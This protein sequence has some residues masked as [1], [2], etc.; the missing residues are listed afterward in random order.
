MSRNAI[1]TWMPFFQQWA[2]YC[3][4]PP[5]VTRDGTPLPPLTSNKYL[6]HYNHFNL[7]YEKGFLQGDKIKKSSLFHGLI[8]I[9][10]P[11]KNQTTAFAQYLA[12]HLGVTGNVRNDVNDLKESDM[13]NA[14]LPG[15]QG[16]VCKAAI[17]DGFKTI[18]VLGKRDFYSKHIHILMVGC[19]EREIDAMLLSQK[20]CKRNNLI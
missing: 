11:T 4:S 15:N 7:L 18:R 1:D 19:S 8:V 3:Q 14:L 13:M 16:I 17:S 12:A 9:V 10:A 20:E 6:S 5:N 2:L